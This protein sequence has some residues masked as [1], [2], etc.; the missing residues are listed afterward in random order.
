MGGPSLA[1]RALLAVRGG[2]AQVLDSMEVGRNW[3]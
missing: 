2:I 1:L 3:V